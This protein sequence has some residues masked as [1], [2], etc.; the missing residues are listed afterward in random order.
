M[1]HLA[2]MA[3]REV[4]REVYG[5]VEVGTVSAVFPVVKPARPVGYSQ[6]RNVQPMLL[7]P[8]ISQCQYLREIT[9]WQTCRLSGQKDNVI[10][11][12]YRKMTAQ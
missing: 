5:P 3:Q 11:Y 4:S 1:S 2:S 12:G 6:I 10:N 7:A 8:I 9:V